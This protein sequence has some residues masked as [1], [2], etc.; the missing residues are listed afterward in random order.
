[1]AA[2]EPPDIY[3]IKQV[4][5]FSTEEIGAMCDALDEL[6]AGKEALFAVI[7]QSLDG[8]LSAEARK[9]LLARMP[10]ATTGIVF[11]NVSTLARIGISLGKKAF[12]MMTRG[13]ELPTAFV[14]TPEQA[15]AW[16]AEQRRLRTG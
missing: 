12:A 4:G 11:V 3:V 6:V 16:V 8:K 14:D 10:P 1:M 5:D 9:V 7:E 13:K 2:F 15:R